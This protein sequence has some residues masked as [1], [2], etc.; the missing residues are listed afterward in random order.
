MGRRAS[1]V[2]LVSTM[3][4]LASALIPA[5]AAESTG[6]LNL[7]FV[8][9][10]VMQSNGNLVKEPDYVE[11]FAT[12]LDTGVRYPLDGAGYP[13][14]DWVYV[15]DGRYTLQAWRGTGDYNKVRSATSWWPG[16][17]SVESTGTF[18]LRH[19]APSDCDAYA[20]P[21]SGCW[22]LF[23]NVQLQENRTLTGAVRH[24]STDGVSDVPITAIRSTEPATRF[25]TRSDAAGRYTLAI[26]PGSYRLE[27]PNGNTTAVAED[28]QVAAASQSFDL[29][30]ADSPTAPREVTAAS[31]SNL[32]SIAWT[33]PVDD[34]GR[35][36]DSY[37]ATAWPG[38]LSCTSSSRLGCEITGLANNR[39]YTF[40]VT[41]TN[42]VGTSV[43]ST[44]SNPVTPV[45][46][47]P[48]APQSVRA[49]GSNRAATISW[50]PPGVGSDTVTGYRVTSSPGGFTCATTDLTCDIGGLQNGV[51]YT[52]RVIATS[53]GGQS[54]AS[55]P[56]NIATPAG[57]PTSPR[58]IQIVAGNASLLVDWSAPAD[59]GG[60]PLTQYTATAWPGGQTCI[61]PAAKRTCSIRGLA[62]ATNYTVTVTATNRVG[63]SERSPGAIVMTTGARLPSQKGGPSRTRLTR[64]T[65]STGKVAVRWSVSG[66]HRVSLSWQHLNSGKRNTQVV[67]PSGQMVLRGA[68][69]DRYLVKIRSLG[70]RKVATQKTFRIP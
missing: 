32:A 18:T 4:V 42:A 7:I 2:P 43:P 6:Q 51:A 57:V 62:N 31:G 39:A 63:T 20:P 64:V 25:T 9:T 38:G 21:V 29:T 26:P 56:S 45:D 13:G 10:T 59:D 28:V 55:E 44:P 16:V 34:G 8:T 23:W 11:G 19:D 15:P 35:K 22:A 3:C 58:N 49:V 61:V 47:A 30:L 27:S 36:I 12:N 5:H 14:Q 41:A 68:S 66:V 65:A 17:F 1:A 54:P 69:G 50:L 37:R 33:P 24:R 52:F 60:S 40:T 67:A 53:T 46:P 70:S 48:D